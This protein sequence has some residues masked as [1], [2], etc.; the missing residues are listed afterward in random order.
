V[1]IDAHSGVADVTFVAFQRPDDGVSVILNRN[2][3]I[4]PVAVVDNLRYLSNVTLVLI[5][6]KSQVRDKIICIDMTTTFL[7]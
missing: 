5:G 7:I 6:V 1:R 3:E 4:V 2:E